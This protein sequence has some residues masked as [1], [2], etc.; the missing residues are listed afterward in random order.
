MY[1][2]FGFIG[3]L[4]LAAALAAC[5]GGGGG[6]G[7]G[8]IPTTAP[9]S[10]ATPTSGPSTAPTSTPVGLNF[11]N[12]VS[13]AL[14]VAPGA[15]YSGTISFQAGSGTA[16]MTASVGVPSSTTTLDTSKRVTTSI[17]RLRLADSAPYSA[18]AYI[19]L[20]ANTAV[21]IGSLPV[22]T[23]SSPS[24]V[25][26][27]YYNADGYWVTL[28]QSGTS[29]VLS[30][31]S[32]AYFAIYTGGTLPSPNPAGCVGVQ[33]DSTARGIARTQ[34]LGVQPTAGA[35]SYTGTYSETIYR[36]TPCPIP[37]ATSNA[38][39]A[40][41]VTMSPGPSGGEYENSTE[42]DTYTNETVTT[43]TSA[44]VEATPVTNGTGFSELSETTTDEVGDS[45][46]TSYSTPLLYAVE[47]P[48]PY[49]T[50]YSNGPPASVDATL[51]DGTTSQR[52]YTATGGVGS[53]TENDTIAGVSGDNTIT[54]SGFSGSYVIQTPN[55]EPGTQFE[56][57]YSAPSGGVITLT[58]TF[59]GVPGST[60]QIA[61]WWP[62]TATSLYTDQTTSS[63]STSSAA[64]TACGA[65]ISGL[66]GN[67]YL[68][69]R[70][71]TTIDPVLGYT[72]TRIVNSYIASN[73]SGSGDVVGPVCVTISDT[74][75][76]YY[77]YFLDT[78][79][80][81][82]V[83]LTGQAL[84]TDT[85]SESY[86]LSSSTGPYLRVRAQSVS[87][88][89]VPGLQAS[90]AAHLSAI[91]FR[92]TIERTERMENFVRNVTSHVKGVQ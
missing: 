88:A 10:T 26:A 54:V 17:P 85:I 56:F 89:S 61:Q 23:V 33:P 73:Y 57:A 60:L 69:T 92:R 34:A 83:S 67:V 81:V 29:L 82:Y 70:T 36:Q 39:V 66:S 9:S 37:T 49:P 72:D 78:P 53:Y 14:P 15:S 45:T 7:G 77:D 41:T 51:A 59:A 3:A 86:Y 21:A 32:S 8:S 64:D 11:A 63:D 22:I 55:Y 38:T 42:T 6:G 71:I 12:A 40:I 5:G 58:P 79:Y 13:T 1:A 47:T 18:V 2:R 19:T 31:G 27:A 90:I 87:P 48:L 52:T 4:L 74:E 16:T 91:D 80:S 24:G 46:Q 25:S 75:N 44:L 35:Y 65:T 76:L 62:S 30:S 28:P 84:Q 20:T 68:F 43:N 50:A